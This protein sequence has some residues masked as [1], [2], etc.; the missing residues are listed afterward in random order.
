MYW[1]YIEK[2][3]KSTK[4]EPEK[5][6]RETATIIIVIMI[7]NVRGWLIAVKKIK[8]NRNSIITIRYVYAYYTHPDSLAI[9]LHLY[10]SFG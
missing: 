3:P 7:R 8:W 5:N 10:F 6:S 2:V 4:S 9:V 1:N